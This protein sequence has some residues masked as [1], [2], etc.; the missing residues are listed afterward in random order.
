M[1]KNLEDKIALVTRA[2]SGIGQATAIEF[3]A[4]KADVVVSDVNEAGLA[5]T[6]TAIEAK[7]RRA[8]ALGLDVSR[9]EQVE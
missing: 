9:P 5:E 2:A 8:L 1:M 4:K 7:G 3:A 6:V